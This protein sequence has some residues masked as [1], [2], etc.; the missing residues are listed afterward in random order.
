VSWP[1]PDLAFSNNSSAGI[2]IKTAYDETSLTVTFY[3]NKE[4][5]TVTAEAGDRTDPTTF[6]EKRVANPD[7][8]PGQEHV[9]Q[10][11]EDGFDIIVT[12]VI[13]QNGHTTRQQFYTRYL[14]EP[15]IIEVGPGPS[16]SPSA[17]PRGTGPP[18]PQT[19]RPRPTHPT[20]APATT[21]P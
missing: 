15:R 6:K 19:P 13:T 8:P 20:P 12:R 2:L 10:S 16:P 9:K 7:L 4:G 11:G 1:R 21:P 5:K 17:S 3:G 14:A 18:P